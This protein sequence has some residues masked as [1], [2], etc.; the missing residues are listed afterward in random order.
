MGALNVIKDRFWGWWKRSCQD[1]YSYEDDKT[2]GMIRYAAER[3][4]I[5]GWQAAKRH[6]H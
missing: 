1:D 5:A 3:G 6:R 2:L 4:Y